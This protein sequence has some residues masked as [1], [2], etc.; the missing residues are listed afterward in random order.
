MPENNERIRNKARTGEAGENTTQG[1]RSHQ[2]EQ[3]GI[4]GKQDPHNTI[5]IFARTEKHRYNR[6]QLISITD[7]DWEVTQENS[8]Q[9][10]IGRQQA[11]K[12]TIEA[13]PFSRTSSHVPES[14]K[15]KRT[16]HKLHGEDFI[17]VKTF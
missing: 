10:T 9:A 3:R 12:S 14:L 15:V 4:F 2:F 11:E 6:T 17:R 8:T 5:S 13:R 16:L 1:S 7:L